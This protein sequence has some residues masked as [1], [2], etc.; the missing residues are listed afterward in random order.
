MIVLRCAW[1]RRHFGYSRPY[2][3][4]SWRGARLIVTEGMCRACSRRRLAE[5]G[6]VRRTRPRRVPAW[7]PPAG[8]AVTLL[9]ALVLSA[10]PAGQPLSTA[11]VPL[12]VATAPRGAGAPVSDA[13]TMAGEAVQVH[14]SAEPPP[15]TRLDGRSAAGSPRGPAPRRAGHRVDAWAFGPPTAVHSLATSTHREPKSTRYM[16]A[17]ACFDVGPRWLVTSLAAVRCSRAPARRGDSVSA[18]AAQAP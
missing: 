14:G 17:S 6:G 5:I 18:P 10:R 16:R 9:A 12:G 3:I 15:S 8:L 1:H 2:G 13:W 7:F 11:T 4:A